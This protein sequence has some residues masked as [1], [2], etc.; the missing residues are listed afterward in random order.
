M[1]HN[2]TVSITRDGATLTS[3]VLN[4]TFGVTPSVVITDNGRIRI[5]LQ[6]AFTVAKRHVSVGL[7]NY[8]DGVNGAVLHDDEV[9]ASDDYIALLCLDNAG[10]ASNYM[11]GVSV[12]ITVFA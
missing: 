3:A 5:A 2:F 7:L 4:N 6:G 1:T 10:N 11:N 8:A 12:S 9:S